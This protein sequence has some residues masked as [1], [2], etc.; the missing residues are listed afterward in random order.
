VVQIKLKS[1]ILEIKM[2]FNQTILTKMKGKG[3]VFLSE[4][5]PI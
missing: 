4:S 5:N 2:S 1:A 3:L